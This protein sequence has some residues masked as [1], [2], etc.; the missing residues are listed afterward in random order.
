ME[1][2]RRDMVWLGYR[3][4]IVRTDNEPA[5]VALLH[6][7]LKALKVDVIDQAMPDH[8]PAYDSKANGSIENAVRQVQGI[9][10]SHLSCLQG[11]LGCRIPGDHPIM[12]WMVQHAAW[13]LT[14]RQRGKDGRTAYERLKGRPF[15]KRMVGI[16]EVCLAKLSK[17]AVALAEIPKLAPRWT[18]AVFLGYS[19]E[20]H[21]YVFHS[22]GRVIK[23]RALQRVRQN[24]RWNLR[25]LEEIKATPYSLHRQPH[26]GEVIVRDPSMAAEQELKAREAER[27][28]I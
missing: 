27:R 2:L 13:T 5:I 24:V 4:V 6:G 16:G 11:R 18:A 28:D 10:R 25:A 20:T 14:I 7:V 26:E 21:E 3:R 1:K 19:R 22:H 8:P 23:S 17:R 9:L 15:H 12:A